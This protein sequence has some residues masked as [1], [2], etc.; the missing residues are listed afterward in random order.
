MDGNVTTVVLPCPP[1]Q[2][3]DFIAGLLGRAQTIESWVDGPFEVDRQGVENLFHLIDQR[4]SSQNEASLVQFTARII[5]DN[6]S[7]VLVNSLQEFLSYNEVKPLIALGLHLSWSYLI[8]F[9]NKKFPEKQVIVISFDSTISNY[10]SSGVSSLRLMYREAA[11]ITL[12]IEH[13][14]R[15]WGADIEALLRGQLEMLRRPIGKARRLSNRYSGVIGSFAAA[16][17]F[18]LTLF[19]TYRISS[20]FAASQTARL[21]AAVQNIAPS[22]EVARKLTFL[23]DLVTGGI[24]PRFTLFVAVLLL[25]L[26]V[27]SI[28][29]GVIISEQS[30]VKVPSFVLLTKR[31]R[32]NKEIQAARLKNSWYVLLGTFAGAMVLGVLS[33]AIFYVALKYLGLPS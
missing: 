19:A 10:S 1:D 17:A 27:G 13:T 5:Y 8:K 25:G 3:R 11:P 2:F 24:W 12:R 15:T 26:T 16:T 33:N 4:I 14:D 32:E 31:S 28:A 7:S 29:L 18:M 23:T 21:V 6:R 20:E 9:Q 30:H 22:E